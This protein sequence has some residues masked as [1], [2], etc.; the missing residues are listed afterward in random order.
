MRRLLSIIALAMLAAGCA[1]G[2]GPV[3]TAQRNQDSLA[4]AE[5]GYILAQKGA[6]LYLELPPCVR[7]PAPCRDLNVA[8]TIQR[9][10]RRAT[11]A[12]VA[13]AERVKANPSDAA[14]PALIAA[15]QAAVGDLKTAVP[16][17]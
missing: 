16:A 17:R 7:N 8:L 13:A 5:T 3:T 14:I 9:V 6:I 10:D 15:A 12:F 2:G 1:G 4:A 11:A